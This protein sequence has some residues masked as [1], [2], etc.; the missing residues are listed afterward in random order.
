VVVG[1]GYLGLS[2]GLDYPRGELEACTMQ[3]ARVVFTWKEEGYG[4]K[5]ALDAQYE[6]ACQDNYCSAHRRVWCCMA[7]DEAEV[8]GNAGMTLPG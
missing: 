1:S 7:K 5:A 6:C 3:R 8:E 4:F 2:T